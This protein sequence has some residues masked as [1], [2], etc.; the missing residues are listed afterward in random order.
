M[1]GQSPSRAKFF[2]LFTL[3]K[4]DAWFRQLRDG[5]LLGLEERDGIGFGVSYPGW[6]APLLV[7]S[8]SFGQLEAGRKRP[9]SMP[10]SV[11]RV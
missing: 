1:V 5:L 3:D 8:A 7:G 10:I 6:V 4:D 9:T 2:H 11:P